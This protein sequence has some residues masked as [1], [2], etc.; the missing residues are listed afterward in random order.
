MNP[1]TGIH[2]ALNRVLWQEGDPNQSQ[3]L[4]ETLLSY[5]H[6]AAYVEHME[7]EK[8]ILKAGYLADV[9]MLSEDIF[10]TPKEEM[11]RVKAV[12]TICDGEIT[13][14]ETSRP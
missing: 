5:T 10:K 1:M 6:D 2:A 7:H 4:E 3:T 11:L 13:H 12:L 9:V 14:E 8:G